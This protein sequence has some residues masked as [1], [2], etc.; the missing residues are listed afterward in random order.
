VVAERFNAGIRA[1]NPWHWQ[2]SVQQ[3][4]EWRAID[5]ERA[6]FK[7]FQTE[8]AF[9]VEIAFRESAG[10]VD[11]PFPKGS[12]V[13]STASARVALYEGQASSACAPDRFPVAQRN[14]RANTPPNDWRLSAGRP[15]CHLTGRSQIGVRCR[16]F[17]VFRNFAQLC[18]CRSI[19]IQAW[20][21]KIAQ[22][23]A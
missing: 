20:A 21:S 4:Q 11:A 6:I 23:L 10:V 22:N 5:V 9:P 1:G 12:E 3:P 17:G 18:E 8:V 15:T 14:R 19:P 2:A 16:G 13:V 7:F